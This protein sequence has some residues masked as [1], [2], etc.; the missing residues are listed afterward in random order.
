MA[1][2]TKPAYLALCDAERPA[3]GAC[4]QNANQ[5]FYHFTLDKN[6]NN[7]RKKA[8]TQPGKIQPVLTELGNGNH[9]SR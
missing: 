7:I 6:I 8:S 3:V 1:S 2:N 5:H 4:L 9:A